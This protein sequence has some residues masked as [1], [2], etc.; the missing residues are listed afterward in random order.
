[1]EKELDHI[2]NRQPKNDGHANKREGQERP[3]RV[4]DRMKKRGRKFKL[5]EEDALSLYEMYHATNL[6]IS[7]LAKLFRVSG[8]T[9][10]KIID[11]KGKRS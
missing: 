9:A 2:E 4:F 10:G 6:N 8:P 11:R 7:Q 3:I 5:S 1:M